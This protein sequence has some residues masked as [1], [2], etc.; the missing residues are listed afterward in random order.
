MGGERTRLRSRCRSCFETSCRV[1][2]WCVEMRVGGGKVVFGW[3]A[4]VCPHIRPRRTRSWSSVCTDHHFVRHASSLHDVKAATNANHFI[5]LHHVSPDELHNI[6]RRK[7]SI[8][9]NRRLSWNLSANLTPSKRHSHGDGRLEDHY[10]PLLRTRDHS[11]SKKRHELINHHRSSQLASSSSYSPPRSSKTTSPSSLSQ[12][13]LLRLYQIG[14][15]AKLKGKMTSWTMG[16]MGLS[17]S[18][19]LS[20]GSWL[21]WASVSAHPIEI[22]EDEYTDVA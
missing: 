14:S 11:P 7:Y 13:I 12:H 19:G 20:R 4:T 9:R 1:W 2:M 10:R 22:T 3:A 5:H 18:G 15:V 6:R 8:C 21:L 17:S 16:A